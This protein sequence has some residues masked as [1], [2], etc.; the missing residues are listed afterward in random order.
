MDTTSDLLFMK[1]IGDQ[2]NSNKIALYKCTLLNIYAEF[3]EVHDAM[4]MFH[5][6]ADLRFLLFSQDENSK[7]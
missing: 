7:N 1:N 5:D 6:A 2:I 4:P 3:L